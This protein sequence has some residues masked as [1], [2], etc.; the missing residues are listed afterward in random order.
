MSG[1]DGR[2]T[3]FDV[4]AVRGADMAFTLTVTSGGSPVNLSAATIDA[5]VYG[6]T[7]AVVDAMTDSV[8]GAGSNVIT[9]SFTDAETALL[10]AS[11]YRWTL[12]VTRGGDKRP[13]LAGRFLVVDSTNGVISTT[14]DVTLTVDGDLSVAVDVQVIGPTVTATD[15][16]IAD[17]GGFYTGSTVEAALQELPD[18]YQPRT[19]VLASAPVTANEGDFW[20]DTDDLTLYSYYDGVWVAMSGGGAGDLV[21]ANNLS[22]VASAATAL[23][24]LGLT[25]VTDA[26]TGRLSINGVEVGDTG[27]RCLSR[28][29][30]GAYDTTSGLVQLRATANLTLHPTLAGGVWI[31]RV[32]STVVLAA[33]R[34]N[35]A[36]SASAGWFLFDSSIGAGFKCANTPFSSTTAANPS[37][38]NYEWACHS[39]IPSITRESTVA[40]GG[41]FVAVSPSGYAISGIGVTDVAW[42]TSLPGIASSSPIA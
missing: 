5:E 10:T 7:G 2:G 20:V 41:A 13:W 17:A 37:S 26:P 12:W 33:S 21:A 38:A 39:D 29:D 22:D 6:P 15:V 8:G 34:I 30:A 25:V 31:R 11:S 42:P 35:V 19:S 4:T 24:N 18:Q 23:A 16:A 28:W 40:A 27:W 14:G 9:L 1:Y 3:K 32:G 36:A